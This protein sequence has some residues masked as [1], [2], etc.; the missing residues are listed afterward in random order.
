MLPRTCLP[1]AVLLPCLLAGASEAATFCVSDAATLR[2]ALATAEA[3]GAFDTI[4]VAMG[5]YAPVGGAAAFEYDANEG[6]GLTLRG[7]YVKVD[8]QCVGPTPDPTLTVLSGSNVMPVLR[9][10]GS[11]GAAGSIRVE[12][13]TIRS[14]R[15]AG[16]GGGGTLGGAG[17]QGGIT[18]ERVIVRNNDAELFGGGLSVATASVLRISNSLFLANRAGSGHAALSVAAERPDTA[19]NYL[20]GNTLVANGCLPG[21][22][23][24]AVMRIGSSSNA[25]VVIANNAFGL[26]D[27]GVDLQIDGSTSIGIL[28]NNLVGLSGNVAPASNTGNLALFSPG[29][30]DPLGGNY[31][32]QVGSP[33][34][35]AGHATFAGAAPDLDGLPRVNGGS[36]DIGA[37][38]NQ[39]DLFGDGFE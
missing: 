23:C 21:D 5:T 1:I 4:A 28:H 7:G 18:V 31:R 30:V 20:V 24:A 13:L 2:G 16:N 35:D 22:S 17:F 6:F 39:D 3:N 27:A 9:L 11:A 14:G 34:R 12:N 25:N 29:F 36:V 15:S 33:L 32:L 19:L 37:Y 10:G 8:G 26:N 38:E